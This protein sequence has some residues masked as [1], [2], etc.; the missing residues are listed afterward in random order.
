LS[1]DLNRENDIIYKCSETSWRA[2]SV[3]KMSDGTEKRKMA[4][5]LGYNAVKLILELL[6]ST[7]S[8]V[9]IEIG[10]TAIQMFLDGHNYHQTISCIERLRLVSSDLPQ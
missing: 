6:R 2:V 9:A 4:N 7:N 1:T 8:E 10:M 5:E 3:H